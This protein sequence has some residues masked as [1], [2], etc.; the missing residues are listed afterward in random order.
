MEQV[1][2]P[3]RRSKRNA[4]LKFIDLMASSTRPITGT[5]SI[6]FLEI[7]KSYPDGAEKKVIALLADTKVLRELKQA[8]VNSS[9]EDLSKEPINVIDTLCISPEIIYDFV[10]NPVKS[11]YLYRLQ[12][13][14]SR[15]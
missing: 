13:V 5:V 6:Y 1:L 2:I 7:I 8:S 12:R 9:M 3:F 10:Q 14:I 15:L 4:V 11:F